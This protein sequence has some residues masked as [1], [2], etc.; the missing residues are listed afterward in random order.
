[1][2]NKKTW[3]ALLL[4][5]AVVL[6]AC[7]AGTQTEETTDGAIEQTDAGLAESSADNTENEG[8]NNGTSAD[9]AGT[10]EVMPGE[11]VP[12]METT[13]LT[14]DMYER[15]TQFL[16]GD[17]TRLAQAMR[18][19]ASGEDVTVAV[20]GGSITEGYSSSGADTCYAAY[21]R[22]WWQERFP[23]TNV[24]YINAGI[25]GTPSYLGVH[26]VQEDVLDYTPDVVIVEFSV[27]DGN[28]AFYQ[29]SYDNLV[30]RILK[31]EQQ[32]AVMLLFTT[33]DN[34]TSAQENDSLVGFRYRLPMLSYG[35]A[36]LPAIEAGEFTWSDISPDSV[37]PNDRGHAI[38][39]EILYRYL[40][41]VYER[42]DEISEEV[43]PF[44]EKAMTKESYQNAALYCADD[45]EP[46]SLGSFEERQVNWYFPD[47]WYTEG[48]EEPL[49]FQ[50]EAS[51][52]GLVYQRTTNGTYGQ[53]DV[54]VD[55]VLVRTL[56]GNFRDG[57]GSAVESTEVYASD[58]TAVHTL[59]IKKSPDS[60]GDIFT[61]IGVLLSQYEG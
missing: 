58:E 28:D 52:I 22:D 20:I 26:R 32:P 54:Y 6:T 17:L 5:I 9:T 14:D 61:L 2:R 49:V 29:K 16:E 1:M 18:K 33:Q 42:L 13:Y 53:F 31:E 57:W 8:E 11:T 23:Q 37:H 27:N 24:N 60:T 36:V 34:G 35:N 44:T 55:G 30:R 3:A 45:I 48:G 10:G 41:D 21:F 59:E 4:S 38:I 47:N 46:I 56:D 19:A 51:N 43:A 7:G 15:A 50:V 40:N 12:V 39:G 25:G